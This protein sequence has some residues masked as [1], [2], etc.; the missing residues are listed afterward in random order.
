MENSILI[1]MEFHG[2]HAHFYN[3]IEFGDHL[4]VGPSLEEQHKSRVKVL[5]Q[6]FLNAPRDIEE[7]K[8]NNSGH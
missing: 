7:S 5:R 2:A 4:H 8:E 1:P 6:Q 3:W